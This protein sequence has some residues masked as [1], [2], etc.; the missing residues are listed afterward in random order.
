[1]KKRS[2]LFFVFNDGFTAFLTLSVMAGLNSDNEGP[3]LGCA[4]I[5]AE[6]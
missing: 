5:R 2:S 4:Q 6:L 3:S 1:M